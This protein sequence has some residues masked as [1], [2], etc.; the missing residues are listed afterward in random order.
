MIRSLRYEAAQLPTDCESMTDYVYVP[1]SQPQSFRLLQLLPHKEDQ[2]NVR[3]T[4]LEYDLAKGNATRPFEALSYA[5][6]SAEKTESVIIDDRSFMVTTNLHSALRHLQDDELPRLF[7]I[8]AICINQSDKTEKEFQVSCMAEIYAKAT[9]VIVWLGDASDDSHRAFKAMREAAVAAQA[10]ETS[11]TDD[12]SRRAI[13]NILQRPWFRR[14]WVSTYKLRMQDE[15]LSSLGFARS[16]C[17][18]GYLYHVW[19]GVHR[20][21]GFL[22]RR[23]VLKCTLGGTSSELPEA[24]SQIHVLG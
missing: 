13:Q 23:V 6:G 16:S 4:L 24:R 18:S 19:I 2:A 17:S 9:R 10:S 12:L 14:I 1:L 22:A 20:R 15:L 11:Q 7:W 3:C 5:W 21:P 8:D